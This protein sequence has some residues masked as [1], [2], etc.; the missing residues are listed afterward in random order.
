MER[1]HAVAS[2]AGPGAAGRQAAGPGAAGHA[3]AGHE[4]AGHR[5]GPTAPGTVILSL[6]P[7]VGALVIQVPAHLNGAEIEISR[8][9]DS[10]SRRTHSQV[11]E[12]PAPG[13]SRFAAVYP[14]LP[15]GR[16]TIWRDQDAPAGTVTVTCAEVA[17]FDWPQAH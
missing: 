4:A 17:R 5:H 7:G 14:D 10:A 13:G 11:R 2:T 6:G 8:D 3:P 15:A 12:R 1:E 9:D 16:Y